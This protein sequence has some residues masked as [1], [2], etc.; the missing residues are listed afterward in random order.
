MRTFGYPVFV[1][2]YWIDM[3]LTTAEQVVAALEVQD[4]RDLV[5]DDL[6][7]ATSSSDMPRLA[8]ARSAGKYLA[9]S[10]P[11]AAMIDRATAIQLRQGGAAVV[12]T[13]QPDPAS[14]QSTNERM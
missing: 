1:A 9:R 10:G 8:E 7:V 4:H 2:C 5:I 13:I 3:A 11:F 14:D 6:P 12:G